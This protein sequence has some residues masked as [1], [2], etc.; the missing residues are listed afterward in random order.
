MLRS[1]LYDAFGLL[2]LWLWA[3]GCGQK[4]AS[5]VYREGKGNDPLATTYSAMVPVVGM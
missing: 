4:I 3:C 5:W 1:A 2:S